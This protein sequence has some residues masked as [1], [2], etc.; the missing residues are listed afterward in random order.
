MGIN[1]TLDISRSPNLT[2]AVSKQAVRVN[3]ILSEMETKGDFRDDFER[4]KIERELKRLLKNYKNRRANPQDHLMFSPE[5]LATS[6]TARN[7]Q[8]E[9]DEEFLRTNPAEVK[10]ITDPN[11][12]D[13]AKSWNLY[14]SCFDPEEMDEIA[15]ARECLGDTQSGEAKNAYLLDVIKLPGAK[16]EQVTSAINGN[17]INAGTEDGEEFSFGA[18]GYLATR[19]DL[20]ESPKIAEE[21]IVTPLRKNRGYGSILARQFEEHCSRL[22]QNAGKHMDGIL[23]EARSGS[24]KFW[25]GKFGAG[26]ACIRKPDG[27]IERVPYFAPSLKKDNPAPVAEKLAFKPS[28]PRIKELPKAR[29]LAM[30]RALFDEWYMEDGIDAEKVLADFERTV[31][32]SPG[33]TILLLNDEELTRMQTQ[34]NV[35]DTLKN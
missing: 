3:Q 34:K 6:P 21:E 35:R 5:V 31:L 7:I 18:I 28:D 1:S 19:E 29:F 12:P 22:T 32:E 33:D 15:V 24:E 2:P 9:L 25:V 23:L 8:R 11:D 10:E 30:V 16:G 17:L 26:Y 4:G 14:M 13:L 27:S 20:H